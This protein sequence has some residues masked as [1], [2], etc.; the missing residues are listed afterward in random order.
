[1]NKDKCDFC[2]QDINQC[3]CHGGPQ[4]PRWN[5]HALCSSNVYI[6]RD[7]SG[8]ISEQQLNGDLLIVAARD[9]NLVRCEELLQSGADINTTHSLSYVNDN[10]TP[11]LEAA[12]HGHYQLVQFLLE[13]GANINIKKSLG[14][15]PL[16][17]AA[18]TCGLTHHPILLRIL[19]FSII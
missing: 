14:N 17:S 1:M 11:I 7:T 6:F 8:G 5:T 4:G 13:R 12:K 9:G 10:N 19:R 16:S 15:T 18:G 3:K 2:H